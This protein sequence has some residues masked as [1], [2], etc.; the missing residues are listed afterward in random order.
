M[1]VKRGLDL[2]DYMLVAFGGSGPL[3]AGRL[4]DL[5]G[6]RAALI[7]PSPGNVSAF[8]LLMVD[9]KND[10]VQTSVQRHDRLDHARRRAR[11]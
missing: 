9:L 1:S 10:Y 5:L 2:R 3:L 8:G 6:L 4:V 7:P 11:T